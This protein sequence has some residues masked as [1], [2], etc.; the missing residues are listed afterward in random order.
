MSVDLSLTVLS[1][2]IREGTPWPRPKCPKCNFGYIGFSDPSH[3]E[4]FES[5]SARNQLEFEPEWICGTFEVRGECENPMCR[6]I[7]HGAGDYTVGFSPNSNLDYEYQPSYVHFYSVKQIHPSILIMSVPDSAPEV[8]REGILRAS[9]VLFPDPGLAA[10]ALR[11]TVERFLT[12]EDIAAVGKSGQ[13]RSAHDRIT[14]WKNV[15]ESRSPIAELLFAVKWIGNAGTHEVSD[16]TTAEVLEGAKVLNEAFHK[17]F[18]AAGIEEYARSVN[19][20]KGPSRI[21]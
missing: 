17:L 8:V 14:E 21:K 1:L 18:T 7:V 10:T 13:F 16:L 5:F 12:S 11:A 20:A 2:P 19:A 6:Q 3:D 15:D 9:R 4:S